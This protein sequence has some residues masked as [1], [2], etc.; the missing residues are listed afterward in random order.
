MFS[1]RDQIV[2]PSTI[3][4][5]RTSTEVDRVYLHVSYDE[6]NEAKR[7]GAKWDNTKK[8]WYT[9]PDNMSVITRWGEQ[10]RILTELI[11]EDRTFGG[12]ELGVEFLPKKCWCKNIQYAIHRHDRDRTKDFVFGRENRTCE[13][14]GLQDVNT[15]FHM[16]GRWVYEDGV[17]RLVRLMTLCEHCYNTTHFGVAYFKGKRE[18]ALAQLKKVTKKS[19]VECDVHI[20]SAY[21]HARMLNEQEW[22]VDLSL[23]TNNGIQCETESRVRSFFS[24]R[25]Q[26]HSKDKKEHKKD[27]DKKDYI[28][29]ME[30]RSGNTTYSFRSN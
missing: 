23:F 2:E 30:H 17:Q 25:V 1:F 15:E 20:D 16:H 26:A 12:D 27:C 19:D 9:L 8:K 10:A 24:M 11:G 5:Q 13:T 28:K 21:E 29:P 14:C 22:K 6:K 7:M 18:E 3:S 4:E